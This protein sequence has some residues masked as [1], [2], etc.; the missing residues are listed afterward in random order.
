MKHP[1]SRL[2]REH[3]GEWL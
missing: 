3:T 1:W 2:R